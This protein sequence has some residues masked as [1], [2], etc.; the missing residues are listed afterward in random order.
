MTLDGTYTITN[1]SVTADIK[2][3]A[4]TASSTLVVATNDGGSKF[5]VSNE[6]ASG[7]ATTADHYDLLITVEFRFSR[8][9]CYQ[10]ILH[11]SEQGRLDVHLHRYQRDCGQ[12]C[13]H[14]IYF[15]QLGCQPYPRLD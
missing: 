5:K 11:D 7:R 3:N 6:N 10:R 1:A 4:D 15:L 8:L 13:E 2:P 12:R 9:G 14:P